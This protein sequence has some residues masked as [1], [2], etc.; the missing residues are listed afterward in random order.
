[1]RARFQTRRWWMKRFALVSLCAM[2]LALP[3][4]AEVLVDLRIDA[5]V[6]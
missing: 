5:P 4:A 2:T 1:M 6:E 3:A